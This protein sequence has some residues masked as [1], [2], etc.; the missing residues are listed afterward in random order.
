M[1]VYRSVSITLTDDINRTGVFR[2]HPAVFSPPVKTD[3]VISIFSA[4]NQKSRSAQAR[5]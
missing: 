4:E 1:S 3:P 5:S 2:P